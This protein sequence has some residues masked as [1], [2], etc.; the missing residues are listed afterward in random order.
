MRVVG[1]GLWDVGVMRRS[2]NFVASLVV[3][4]VGKRGR[5]RGERREKSGV[6]IQNSEFRMRGKRRE[7]CQNDFASE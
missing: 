5:G 3:S 6:R 4:F 2:R 1:C 7:F